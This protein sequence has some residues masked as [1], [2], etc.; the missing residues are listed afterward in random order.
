VAAGA[1]L[2]PESR[3]PAAGPA[4][5]VGVA[6]S[7]AGL[8]SLIYGVIEAPSRGWTDPVTLTAFAVAVVILAGFGWWELRSAHPMLQLRL[9]RD[10]RFSAASATIALAFFALFGALFFL[11]QYLQLVLTPRCPA[12]TTAR[13]LLRCCTGGTTSPTPGSTWPTSSPR[14]LPTP[15][16]PAMSAPTSSRPN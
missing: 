8:G 4:D 9:F 14:S 7:I 6:L 2:V 3:D 5:P 13:S 12:G 11:T 16:R 10:R 15:S 1:V